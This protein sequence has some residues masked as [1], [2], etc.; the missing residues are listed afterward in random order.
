MFP[1]ISRARAGSIGHPLYRPAQ[2][3]A[4]RI[5]NPER[6]RVL[7]AADHP[8]CAVA[9]RFASL[10]RWTADMLEPGTAFPGARYALARL[11]ITRPRIL[12]LDEPAELVSRALRPSL[13]A[14]RARE[15][16]QRWARAIHAERAWHGVRWWSVHEASWGAVG[17]W[18]ARA[19]RVAS[20]EPLSLAH[21]ALA[22]AAEVLGA[23]A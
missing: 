7:Y 10:P 5:D 3:G 12:D 13:V 21:P 18:D 8:A 15:T 1:W 11:V 9:E 2:Q 17:L 16:T 23:R 4:G 22:E 19:V 6:Y 14:T 20:I